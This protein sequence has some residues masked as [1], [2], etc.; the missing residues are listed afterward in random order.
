MY[1]RTVP[2]ISR[3]LTVLSTSL[4]ASYSGYALY[5]HLLAIALTSIC[6]ISGFDWWYFSQTR[7]PLLFTLLFP[8]ALIGF[9]VPIFVPLGLY[10]NGSIRKRIAWCEAA[11][12]LF[13]AEIVSSFIAATYKAVTGRAHPVLFEAGSSIDIS[14]DFQFGFLEGGIFWGWPSS[15]TAVAFSFAAVLFV[16][17]PEYR[18]RTWIFFLYALYIG[19]GV[20]TTIHWFSDFVAGAL[21][22]TLAGV[23]VAHTLIYLN[24]APQKEGASHAKMSS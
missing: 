8:S 15:H 9:I 23:S 22:G 5:I 16:L 10:V 17:Y 21:F 6:V 19:I 7:S 2:A 24:N 1:A 11:L 14:R 13:A 12:A 18:R 20:S 3:S 4:V